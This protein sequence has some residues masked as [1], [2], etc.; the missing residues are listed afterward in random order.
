VSANGLAES[1]EPTTTAA[2]FKTA[3]YETGL[4]PDSV[5]IADLFYFLCFLT[6]CFMFVEELM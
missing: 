1:F 6:F 3:S 5:I 2:S 4:W